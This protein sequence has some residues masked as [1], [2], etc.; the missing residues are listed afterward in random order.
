MKVKRTTIL[1]LTLFTCTYGIQN[2]FRNL[3]D[4]L[5]FGAVT[6]AYQIEG[7]WES[8]GKKEN[9][10]DFMTHNMPTKIED[11]STGDI[12]CDSYNKIKEDVEMLKTVGFQYYRFSISW[13]RILPD[14]FLYNINQ[15]GIDYYN[16]LIDELIANDIVPMVTIYHWDLPQTLQELGGW[17]NSEMT[18]WFTDFSNVLFENYGDRVKLWITINEPKQICEFGYG[19]GVFA[20]AYKYS[21]IGDYLCTKNVLLAHASAYHLYD[22]KFRKQQQGRIGITIESSWSEPASNSTEDISAAERRR[23]FDFGIYVEPIFGQYG[24]F[25]EVVKNIVKERSFAEGFS[26][27]RLPQLTS[28]EIRYIKGTFDF[29]GINHYTTFYV[30]HTTPDPISTPSRQ[31]DEHVTLHSDPSWLTGSIPYFKLVPWGFRKLLKYFKDNYDNPEVIITENGFPD[32]GEIDDQ[33]RIRYHKGNLNAL[34]DAIEYDDVRATGYFAWSLMDNF[35]WSAGYTSRFGLYY[36]N[37]TDP[38]RERL[39]KSSSLFFKELL[40]SRLLLRNDLKIL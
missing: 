32:T 37:F 4:N 20:P 10:W 30:K 11:G 34:L 25:P 5:I 6:S 18:T 39:P 23:Q 2:E 22:N 16:L 17:A 26:K 14:G 9:I 35:E 3:P 24:D 31:N 29:L 7:A 1:L 27:S 8:D 38:K 40:Q 36:V 12:A 33:N 19:T 28:D 13:T 21:G 15:A